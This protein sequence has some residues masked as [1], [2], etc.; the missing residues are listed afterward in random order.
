LLPA[1]CR[2]ERRCRARLAAAGAGG[3]AAAA[4]VLVPLCSVRGRPALLFT[5]RSRRLAGPHSGDVS[6]PG[7]RRDPADGDTVATALRETREE[8]GVAVAPTS[9]WGQL[10]T[11]PD[12][13]PGIGGGGCRQ[14]RIGMTG[15]RQQG[16]G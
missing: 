4:A 2:S 15:K 14:Q 12:R 5:L 10:R 16:R 8:L 13:V 3:A 11:L 6:F 1:P 9:V 7:G